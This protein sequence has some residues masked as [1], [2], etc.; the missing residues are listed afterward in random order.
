MDSFLGKAFKRAHFL[1]KCFYRTLIRRK[2]AFF[3]LKKEK[4]KMK[5]KGAVR[6]IVKTSTTILSMV[7][8]LLLMILFAPISAVLGLTVALLLLLLGM[9]FVVY[10]LYRLLLA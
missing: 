5:A 4:G 2:L 3:T 1:M 10:A 7:V 8:G 9:G 6:W